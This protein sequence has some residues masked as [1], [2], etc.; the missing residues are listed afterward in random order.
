VEWSGVE[1]KVGDPILP[2]SS[3]YT[4]RSSLKR[5]T[6]AY[7][8]LKSAIDVS[9]V[10]SGFSVARCVPLLTHELAYALPP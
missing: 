8:G 1:E 9:P 10:L 6:T 2:C 4:G 3:R 5:G 7:N